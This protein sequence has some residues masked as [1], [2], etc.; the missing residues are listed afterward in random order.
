MLKLNY[1]SCIYYNV[2]NAIA[3]AGVA[4]LLGP[5]IVDL[6]ILLYTS[7]ASG[8]Y[9]LVPGGAKLYGYGYS[10]STHATNFPSAVYVSTSNTALNPASHTF[11]FY[12]LTGSAVGSSMI[13]AITTDT[14]VPDTTNGVTTLP[15]SNLQ[16]RVSSAMTSTCQ[17]YVTR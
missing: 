1:V 7:N 10:I 12:V 14:W 3:Q 8:S 17:N 5:G 11:D 4:S 6:T 9:I 13:S 16:L 2:D 15:T